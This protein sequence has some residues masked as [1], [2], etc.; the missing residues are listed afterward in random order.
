MEGVSTLL[1]LTCFSSEEKKT[2]PP[3][4]FLPDSATGRY[5]DLQL[6]SKEH[7]SPVPAGH[8][9]RAR[10]CGAGDKGLPQLSKTHGPAGGGCIATSVLTDRRTADFVQLGTGASGKSELHPGL[11]WALHWVLPPP[12]QVDHRLQVS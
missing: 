2:E 10:P 1:L 9:A 4:L 8:S 5:K 12:A 11:T 6:H 3:P 7:K